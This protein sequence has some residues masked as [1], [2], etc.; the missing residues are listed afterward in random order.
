MPSR[1]LAASCHAL[2]ARRV[3][4]AHAASSANSNQHAQSLAPRG[5]GVPGRSSGT[6]RW[7]RAGQPEGTKAQ[8]SMIRDGPCRKASAGMLSAPQG[9][10]RHVCARRKARAAR[11]RT[12]I[13]RCAFCSVRRVI[14]ACANL[15]SGVRS[16]RALFRWRPCQMASCQMRSWPDEVEATACPRPVTCGGSDRVLRRERV[17]LTV[18]G[19]RSAVAGSV[20]SRRFHLIVGQWEL[21]PKRQTAWSS[22]N[23]AY[24]PRNPGLNDQGC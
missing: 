18:A 9:V 11:L 8:V 13:S 2:C 4:F 14:R 12:A 17:S 6:A 24:T 19:R 3:A 23:D 15:P 5:E 22:L 7:I 1:A 10:T 21:Q 16:Q 20:P